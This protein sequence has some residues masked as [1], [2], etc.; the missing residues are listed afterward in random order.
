MTEMVRLHSTFIDVAQ[1][2][3]DAS[4]PQRSRSLGCRRRLAS[5]EEELAY[6]ERLSQKLASVEGK[7]GMAAFFGSNSTRTSS[8]EA[9]DERDESVFLPSQHSDEEVPVRKE[10][11]VSGVITKVDGLMD[12]TVAGESEEEMSSC[13][14]G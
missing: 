10:G 5:V 13:L 6:Y 2:S 12:V 1:V 4:G 7:S 14:P 11:T 9:G 8:T 3:A